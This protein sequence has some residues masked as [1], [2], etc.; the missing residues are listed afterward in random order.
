M[1]THIPTSQCVTVGTKRHPQAAK[2]VQAGPKCNCLLEK[3]LWLLKLGCLYIFSTVRTQTSKRTEEHFGSVFLNLPC[4]RPWAY[5]IHK[6]EDPCY[7][8]IA[9]DVMWKFLYVFSKKET[10]KNCSRTLKTYLL[11]KSSVCLR[12]ENLLHPTTLQRQI[13]YLNFLLRQS[14]YKTEKKNFT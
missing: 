7:P 14:D 6:Q 3:P 8:V 4:Q 1:A 9:V 2:P 12:T 5:F 11:L 13:W 10:C